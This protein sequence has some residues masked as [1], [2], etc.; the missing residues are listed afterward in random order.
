MESHEIDREQLLAR[1]DGLPVTRMHIFVL[2][3]CAL[4]FAFDLAEVAFGNILSAVFSA[5]PHPIDGTQ[6]SWLLSS[7]YIG[8]VLGAPLLGLLAD[9]FGRRTIMLWALLILMATSAAASFS[10][11]IPMLTFFRGVSGIALGGYPPLMIAFMTDSL[12]PSRRGPLV[13]FA[14]AIGYLGPPSIFFLVRWLTPL[15]PLGLEG[16]RWAFLI[17]SAGAAVVWRPRG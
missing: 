15:M 6:L 7:V 2:V 8:A 3:A 10:S 17:A 14:V 9:R 5:P 11:S 12:P 4:G 13:M 16:W 1:L